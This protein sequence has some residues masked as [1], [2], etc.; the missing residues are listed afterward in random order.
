MATPTR[1]TSPNFNGAN[2]A[3]PRRCPHCRWD[4]P[5]DE[6]IC[7][8][9]GGTSFCN[10]IVPIIHQVQGGNGTAQGNEDDGSGGAD[11]G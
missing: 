1:F 2:P 3:S 5:I 9:R 11:G 7:R 6:T 10:W 4:N 8:G